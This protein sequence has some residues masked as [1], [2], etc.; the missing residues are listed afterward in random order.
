MAPV[1]IT[2]EHASNRVPAKYRPLFRELAH[3]LDTHRG[4]DIGAVPLARQFAAAFAA[5]LVLGRATRLLVDLNRS[6]GHK[7]LHSDATRTLP[8]HERARILR[9]WYL[10]Y[11]SEVEQHV[12][13]MVARPARVMHI[14]THSFTPELHGEVR[15]A[16]IGL[17]Y[18][19]ARPGEVRLAERWRSALKAAAP[20]LRVRRNYPYRGEQDG[21][22]THLR[23]RHAP[24]RY[25]GME[26]EF[27]QALVADAK[28]W[29]EVRAM[30]VETLRVA[31]ER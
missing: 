5:P 31:L 10:P 2:C 22:T 17:L 29:R 8:A 23:R 21:M 6:I 3:A 27:N 15:N 13:A 7:D 30:L 14:S 16:D 18:D 1:L 20:E 4:Y 28:A 24:Q 11:R 19:P 12:G 26:L 9:D 25:V